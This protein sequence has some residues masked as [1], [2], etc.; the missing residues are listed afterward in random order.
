[1]VSA[2][3]DL[4]LER[5][6]EAITLDDLIARAGGSRRDIY[7]HFGG[8]E[9]L[10]IAAVRRLCEEVAQPMEALPLDEGDLAA[11]LRSYGSALL[12]AVL[13][14]RTLALHRLMVAEGQR[15]P[16]L[17]QAIYHSGHH[18]GALILSAFLERHRERSSAWNSSVPS[19]TLAHQF[20]SLVVAEAQLRASVGLDHIPPTPE[21]VSQ[22]VEYAVD[23]FMNGILSPKGS[24]HA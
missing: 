19:L 16:E 14:P 13:S 1:M 3:A 11:S 9:G 8:K 15:F 17:A 24:S 12:R 2:A 20:V 18:Q 10:F 5:G 7:G 23:V 6:Y 4:F 22:T 21:T